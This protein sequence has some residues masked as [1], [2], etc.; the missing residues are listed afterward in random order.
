MKLKM[1]VAALMLTGAVAAQTLQDAVKQ[2]DLEKYGNARNQLD[3]IIAKDPSDMKAYFYAGWCSI[4][5]EEFSK[6]QTYFANALKLN[7]KDFLNTAGLGWV[8]GMNKQATEAK[9]KFAE[10]VTLMNNNRKLKDA[11]A[12]AL[13]G[14]ALSGSPTI[15]TANAIMMVRKSYE[16]DNQSSDAYFYTGLTFLNLSEGGKAISNFESVLDVNKNSAKAAFYLGN[17]YVRSRIPQEA[18]GYYNKAIEIDSTFAPTYRVLGDLYFQLRQTDKSIENYK[19]Y[20][21]LQDKD[22]KSVFSQIKLASFLLLSNDYT[23]AYDQ[24]TDVLKRDQTN[25][26]SYRILAQSAY[27]TGR[28]AEGLQASNT[29]FA[30]V[31]PTKLKARDYEYA[32]KL[33]MV[34]GQDSLAE[35]ALDQAITL[36]SNLVNYND[37]IAVMYKKLKNYNKEAK[38][39]DIIMARDPRQSIIANYSYKKGLAM[40]FAKNYVEADT[41]FARVLAIKPFTLALL[42]R[43]RCNYAM[44]AAQEGKAIPYYDQFIAAAKAENPDKFKKELVEAYG[45]LGLFYYNKKELDKSKAINEELLKIDPTN[46]NA[47]KVLKNISILKGA[48]N[49]TAPKKS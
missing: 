30:K 25:V 40:Y 6:A 1:L 12:V 49:K 14:V 36:D 23:G 44:D 22:D 11:W 28:Y 43:A 16:L 26:Y 34:N 38:R 7:P 15:D 31:D 19:K 3:A 47:Q 18:I 2:F 29:F 8:A 33:Y 13:G 42:W 46:E 35:I 17:V 39:Y 21:A 5:L 9:S 45:N 20:L 37:T 24:I 41:S 4:E 48:G 27:E 10:A 32:G